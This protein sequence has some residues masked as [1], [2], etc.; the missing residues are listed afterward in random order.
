MKNKITAT[1]VLICA[2]YVCVSCSSSSSEENVYPEKE[3]E[4]PENNEIVPPE[5][6]QYIFAKKPEGGK[7]V[8]I[9]D[10]E[11]DNGYDV[12][13]DFDSNESRWSYQRSASSDNVIV[14]WEKGFGQYPSKTSRQNLRVDINNL[15]KM[16]EDFYVYYRDVMKF[17]VKGDSKTDDYR[18]IIQL[19]YQEEWL[20]TGAGYDDVIGALW[21]NPATTNGGAVIAHEF[22]HSFQY[23]VHCDG[24]Y[25]FRDQP[26]VGSFWE[27]CAQYM[28]WQIN[29]DSYISEL[30]YFLD[31]V[32]KNFSHEDIRYQSMYLQEYWKDKHGV[33]FLGKLWREAISPEHPIETYQRL[34]GISQE[35]FNAEVFQYACKN[36]SWDYPLGVYNNDFIE[37]LSATDQENYKHKTNLEVLEDGYYQVVSNQIPQSYGYNAIELSIPVTGT[38]VSVDFVGLDGGYSNV[39]GWRYGFVAVTNTGSVVG[40]AGVSKL[41]TA[42][43]IIPENA[44]SLWL[45]VT[46]AP[47]AHV[48]HIWDEDASN[49]QKFPYKVKFTNTALE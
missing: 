34:T 19:F 10:H 6:F 36:I 22:G 16:A 29:N 4:T 43:I 7:E 47:T 20:A 28:S 27:Q 11:I 25:G 46:G 2:I 9:P 1:L 14:F 32:H 38:T 18:M 40:E 15:L 23:Q 24:N 8:Y 41:G 49:D 12:Y 21:V 33:D 39:E 13:N 45:I 3:S 5:N 30:P 17:V 37:N 48:N 44:K 26:Y 31:N 35:E 42:D